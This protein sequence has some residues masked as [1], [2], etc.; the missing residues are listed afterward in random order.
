MNDTGTKSDVQQFIA[1]GGRVILSF[2]GADGQYLES[3]CS[4]D[5]M[6]NLVKSV[7]DTQKIHNLDFD[8][9]GGQLGNTTLNTTRNNVIK[10]PVL[11]A[12][13]LHACGEPLTASW[14]GEPGRCAPGSPAVLFLQANL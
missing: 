9:E 14:C 1:Q 6:F 3:A 2:G 10:L 7:I 11:C 13:L 12:G 5:S 4:Q 8:I